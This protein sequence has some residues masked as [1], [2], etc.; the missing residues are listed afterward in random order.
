MEV[1][2]KRDE[3]AHPV[4]GVYFKVV[5]LSC[6]VAFLMWFYVIRRPVSPVSAF[7][8]YEGA[9]AAAAA[10]AGYGVSRREW[11]WAVLG[12]FVAILLVLTGFLYFP[13]TLADCEEWVFNHRLRNGSF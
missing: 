1:A 7:L 10:L 6:V 5:A 8:P 13:L 2:S 11:R 12:A 3:Q 9:L 4:T